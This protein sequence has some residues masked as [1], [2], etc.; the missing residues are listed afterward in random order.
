[1]LVL[2]R[3]IGESLRIGPD[4]TVMVTRISGDHV[5][6]GVEAPRELKILRAELEN[7]PAEP[8]P[9]C[10]KESEGETNG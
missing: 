8:R 9:E 3:K 4:I 5:K 7:C 1:M 2:T 6:L 10:R